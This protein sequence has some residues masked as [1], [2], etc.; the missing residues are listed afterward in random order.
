VPWPWSLSVLLV[1]GALHV[2]HHGEAADGLQKVVVRPVGTV[3][4]GGNTCSMACP[5]HA[6]GVQ[7]WLAQGTPEP[8][9]LGPLGPKVLLFILPM[10]KV[11]SKEGPY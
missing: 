4:P 10:G 3:G 6:L 5:P 9:D 1:H 8:S 7:S 11:R 2:V